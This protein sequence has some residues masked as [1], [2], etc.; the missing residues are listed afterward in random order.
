VKEED[1][2]TSIELVYYTMKHE[3]TAEKFDRDNYLQRQRGQRFSKDSVFL[4][5]EGSAF[6]GTIEDAR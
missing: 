4:Y 2:E 3:Y 6:S 5:E 1:D